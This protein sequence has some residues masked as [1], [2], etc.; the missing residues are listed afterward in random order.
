MPARHLDSELDDPPETMGSLLQDPQ[1]ITGLH[2]MGRLSKV[3]GRTQLSEGLREERRE[4]RKEALKALNNQLH[5]ISSLNNDG[6]AHLRAVH[7]AWDK[8]HQQDLSL[9]G[10]SSNRIKDHD[11]ERS[12]HINVRRE[13]D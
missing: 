8:M 2:R 3:E 6:I 4:V 5:K 1:G 9:V 12:I 11:L 10:N 7:N 13:G